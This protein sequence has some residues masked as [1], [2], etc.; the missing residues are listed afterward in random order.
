ML[1]PRRLQGGRSET[2]GA[3]TASS[4]GVQVTAGGTAN[5]KG[6]WA[7]IGTT[8]FEYNS[9]L[10]FLTQSGSTTA[11]DSVW[12]IAVGSSGN[13]SIIAADLRCNDR[14]GPQSLVAV[15]NLPIRVK[16]G[17]TISARCA[18]TTVSNSYWA[19]I[20]GLHSSIAQASF[21]QCI[22]L[23]TPSSS[24]GVTIDPG[25]INNTKGSWA[26][27]IASVPQE[28]GA[29]LL[30]VGAN[31]D[32]T[33]TTASRIFVDL[34]IGAA[35]SEYVILPDLATSFDAT[36]DNPLPS[37]IGPLPLQLK[38]GVRLAARAQS[39]NATSGDRTIDL[40]VWGLVP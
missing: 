39:N 17:Q 10:V 25:G 21:S 2:L 34:G 33:R 20:V 13:E 16:A 14:K 40:A 27:L 19:L 36:T 30:G 7:T 9:V 32:V 5:S 18:S 8:T 29:I 28:V 38:S 12:D 11:G 3:T 6:S 1:V 15:Y 26:Q 22:A 4:R 24:R 31:A 37:V 23:Y 35:S